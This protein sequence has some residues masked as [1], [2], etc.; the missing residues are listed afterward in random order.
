MSPSLFNGCIEWLDDAYP[1][2]QSLGIVQ[3]PS[4]SPVRSV[5]ETVL[6]ADT[7]FRTII[8]Y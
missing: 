6:G 7:S 5:M 2:V 8:D 1:T 3:M 4:L